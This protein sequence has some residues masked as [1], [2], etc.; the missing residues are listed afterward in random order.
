MSCNGTML[1][2][3]M[4]LMTTCP[5]KCNLLCFLSF[6]YAQLV[7]DNVIKAQTHTLCLETG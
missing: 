7:Q 3:N 5:Y 4:L 6:V 2:Y 1:P